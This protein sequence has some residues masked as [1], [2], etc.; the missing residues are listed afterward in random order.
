LSSLRDE[1]P[2]FNGNFDLVWFTPK[3]EWEGTGYVVEGYT[4]DGG[5]RVVDRFEMRE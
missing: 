2:R 1:V 5:G 4:V 3:V